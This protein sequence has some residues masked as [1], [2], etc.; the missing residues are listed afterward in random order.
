MEGEG[1]GQ[2][3]GRRGLMA[4]RCDDGSRGTY[5]VRPTAADKQSEVR[6]A[7]GW[8]LVS[9]AEAEAEAGLQACEHRK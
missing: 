4:M 1:S 2:K 3:E 9:E 7:S 6:Q 5:F 8:G